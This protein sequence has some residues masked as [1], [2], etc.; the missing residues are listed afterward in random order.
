M[1]ELLKEYS[2]GLQ[3]YFKHFSKATIYK[4]FKKVLL[5]SILIIFNIIA[6]PCYLCYKYG[7][8]KGIKL[9]RDK[10]DKKT[11]TYLSGIH[12]KKENELIS[13]S[14]VNLTNPKKENVKK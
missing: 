13:I 8:Y 6:I 3:N 10:P 9:C 1:T 11:P 5:I 12:A 4:I 2:K 7:L 14:E